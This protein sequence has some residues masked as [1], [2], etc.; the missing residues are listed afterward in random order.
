MLSRRVVFGLVREIKYQILQI[1]Y[2]YQF[3]EF[4]DQG[5]ELAL[6]EISRKKPVLKNRVL[7]AIEDVIARWR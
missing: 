7:Q 4:Y 5:S 3:K 2:F 1:R 6:Q